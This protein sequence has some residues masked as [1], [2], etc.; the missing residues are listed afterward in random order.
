MGEGLGVASFACLRHFFWGS[1]SCLV[2]TSL[3]HC[4]KSFASC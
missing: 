4:S 3:R 1:L 2:E